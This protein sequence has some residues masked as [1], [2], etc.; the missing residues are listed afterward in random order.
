MVKIKS[1]KIVKQG[2]KSLKYLHLLIINEFLKRSVFALGTAN[3]HW[4]LRL[5]WQQFE[6]G[7]KL[8]SLWLGFYATSTNN[9]L[10][11]CSMWSESRGR[12]LALNASEYD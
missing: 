12:P 7:S 1:R 3:F 8:C 4:R 6:S 2:K 5:Y 10:V 9:F 11:K